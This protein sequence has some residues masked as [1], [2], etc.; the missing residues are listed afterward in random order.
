MAHNWLG[1]PVTD[2]ID[3]LYEGI[4]NCLS[5]YFP[6]RNKFR[7]GHYFQA[8]INML[9]TRYYTSPLINLPHEE[10]LKL[11]PTDEFA[12][13]LLLARAWAFVVSMDIRTRWLAVGKIMRPVED[14]AI[15]PFSKRRANSEPY[16][17]EEWIE[18]LQPLLGE[19]L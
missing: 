3:W 2:G 14:L 5:I 7:T 16:G 10:L 11:V 1:P 17:I 12:K 9:C 4:K 19:G 6:F 13:E 15:K 8:T 18:L